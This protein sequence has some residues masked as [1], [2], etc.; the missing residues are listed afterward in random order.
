MGTD[1]LQRCLAVWGTAYKLSVAVCWHR[2]SSQWPVLLLFAGHE[3]LSIVLL[4]TASYTADIYQR[5]RLRE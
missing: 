5:H 1:R 4:L 2:R 3:S